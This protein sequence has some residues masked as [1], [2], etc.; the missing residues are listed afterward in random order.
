MATMIPCVIFLIF[1]AA[2]LAQQ[3]VKNA[4]TTSAPLYKSGTPQVEVEW[5]PQYLIDGN[6]NAHIGGYQVLSY[7]TSWVDVNGDG[8]QDLVF[9]LYD[10]VDSP[11]SSYRIIYLNTGCAFI[12]SASSDFS[13]CAHV[14]SAPATA[15]KSTFM[16]FH[17]PL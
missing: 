13:Y 17:S 2:C 11:K 5:V 1:L 6:G 9:G 16:V 14:Y 3:P 12:D 4:S 15:E 7:G 8:L 10:A